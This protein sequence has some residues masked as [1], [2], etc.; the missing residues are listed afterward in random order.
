MRIMIL[1]AAVCLAPALAR[2]QFTLEQIMGAPFVSELTAAPKG[3]RIAWVANSRGVRNIWVAEGPAFQARRLTPYASD[4]GQELSDLHW[5][6][7][8]ASLVYVRG[9]GENPP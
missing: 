5:T 8:A 9:G 7:D 4:D 6:P 2:A 1:L 3:N